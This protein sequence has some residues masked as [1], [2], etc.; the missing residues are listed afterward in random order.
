MAKVGEVFV[1]PDGRT[2]MHPG[3]FAE[4]GQ[5]A[6]CRCAISPVVNEPGSEERQLI[7]PGAPATESQRL[8]WERIAI[9]AYRRAF[10]NQERDVLAEL[11]RLST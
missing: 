7:P 6:N 4:V 2:A 9:S 11:R 1:F 5:N 10:R 3:E 8:T